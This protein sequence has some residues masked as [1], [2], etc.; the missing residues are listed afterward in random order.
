MNKENL[1]ET[2]ETLR[3][4]EAWK[5]VSGEMKLTPELVQFYEDEIDWDELSCNYEMHWTE[6]LVTQYKKKINW[7]FLSNTLFR[8]KE[9]LENAEHLKIVR[10]LQSEMDWDSLSESYLPTRKEYLKEFAEHWNWENIAENDDILWTNDL[11]IEFEDRLLPVLSNNALENLVDAE[12]CE[13]Y[14]TR[15]RRR[16]CGRVRFSAL[17]NQLI[18]NDADKIKI[19]ILERLSRTDD[20]HNK[21]AKMAIQDLI[22]KGIL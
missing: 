5:I 17:L 4:K 22:D 21:R 16:H 7:T 13:D 8:S 10:N 1:K 11:F 15:R 3:N 19:K 12:D 6:A 2:L 18:E 14:T 9:K 20:I